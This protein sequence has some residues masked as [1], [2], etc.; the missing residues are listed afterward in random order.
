MESM[1]WT[2]LHAPSTAG[3]S[4]DRWYRRAVEQSDVSLYAYLGYKT[5]QR[6][7]DFS[8]GASSELTDGLRASVRGGLSGTVRSDLLNSSWRFLERPVWVTF[9]AGRDWPLLSIPDP[10]EKLSWQEQLASLKGSVFESWF[11]ARSNAG[12]V[13][14]RLLSNERPFEWFVTNGAFRV[15]EATMHAVVAGVSRDSLL[16]SVAVD[17][18]RIEANL[19]PGVGLEQFVDVVLKLC[20]P[21]ANSHRGQ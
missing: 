11:P 7:F 18:E 2:E 15:L 19:V 13:L 12:S 1:G 5:R 17:R 21:A 4:L 20:D 9:D 8:I 14:N 6:A 3:S 10:T 16:A